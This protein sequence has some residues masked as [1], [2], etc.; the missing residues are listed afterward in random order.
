MHG[1]DDELSHYFQIMDIFS[2]AVYLLMMTGAFS[3]NMTNVSPDSQPSLPLTTNGMEASTTEMIAHVQSQPNP[4]TIS[5]EDHTVD[6]SQ[7]KED[8]PEFT[9]NGCRTTDSSEETGMTS[10]SADPITESS[11]A[12]V[13]GSGSLSGVTIAY[14][15]LLIPI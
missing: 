10:A 1:D 9:S 14:F 15:L 3:A 6:T 4:A 12:S 7:C 13:T 8:I 11:P 2:W 5:N